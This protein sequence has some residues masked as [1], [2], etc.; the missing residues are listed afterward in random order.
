[1]C[2]I[3]YDISDVVMWFAWGVT[4]LTWA[5]DAALARRRSQAYAPE[6][7]GERRTRANAGWN[8]ADRAPRKGRERAQVEDRQEEEHEA[9]QRP[10]AEAAARTTGLSLNQGSNLSRSSTVSR[11]RISSARPS[12]T[13]TAA[14]RGTPL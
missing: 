9:R 3:A 6:L 13:R 1:M 11:L 5:V 4:G 14:G 8:D 7:G 10:R 2:H 12:A